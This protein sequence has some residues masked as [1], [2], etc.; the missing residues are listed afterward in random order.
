M[1]SRLSYVLYG[2]RNARGRG[3]V[4]Y[5]VSTGGWGGNGGGWSWGDLFGSALSYIPRWLGAPEPP[6]R[7]SPNR[8]LPMPLPRDLPVPSQPRWR[9]P[10][11]GQG[12]K[13]E[14]PT[15]RQ[16]LGMGTQRRRRRKMQ[17]TNQRALNRAISRIK[18]FQKIVK[19]SHVFTATDQR[20]PAPKKRRVCKCQ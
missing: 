1:I 13:Y 12:G 17:C 5:F 4:D 7:S 6:D 10:Y 2:G 16:E 15:W 20:C 19:K 8:D 14:W 9:L 3:N 11:P 18:C